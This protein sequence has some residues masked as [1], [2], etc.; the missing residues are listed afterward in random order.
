MNEMQADALSMIE[1]LCSGDCHE[2]NMPQLA[3]ACSAWIPQ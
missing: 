3:A 2:K 1:L